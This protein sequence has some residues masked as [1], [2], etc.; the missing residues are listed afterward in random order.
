MHDTG[1]TETFGCD[2][3]EGIVFEFPFGIPGFEDYRVFVFLEQEEFLPFKWLVSV[4]KPEIAFAIADPRSLC[5]SYTVVPSKIDRME[6]GS[7]ENSDISV[8]VILTVSERTV[9]ANLRAPLLVDFKTR[10]GKQ[11]VLSNNAYSVKYLV[12]EIAE[13]EPPQESVSNG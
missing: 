12:S 13:E 9:T 10:R 5:E 1:G 7:A 11:I 3:K 4:K 2:P 6:L 8:F